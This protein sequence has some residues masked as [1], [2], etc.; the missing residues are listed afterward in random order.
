MELCKKHAHC[1]IIVIDAYY[2]SFTCT[3]LK[4][5]QNAEKQLFTEKVS[6]SVIQ[7]IFSDAHSGELGPLSVHCVQ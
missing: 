7:L 4:N 6:Y 2:L 1:W 3:C 5:L